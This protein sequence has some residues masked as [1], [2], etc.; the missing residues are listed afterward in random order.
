MKTTENSH[1]EIMLSYFA[2]S[3]ISV[4]INNLTLYL[5]EKNFLI[6]DKLYLQLNPIIEVSN[7]VANKLKPITN[8]ATSGKSKKYLQN[9]NQ[10]SAIALP[11]IDYDTPLSS[12][13]NY[14][15]YIG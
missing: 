11:R 2:P 3:D 6:L 15:H 4:A 7:P 1:H 5:R 14:V 9:Q 13:N 10:N 12:I 8:Y